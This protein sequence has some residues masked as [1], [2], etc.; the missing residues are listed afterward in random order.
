MACD[1][2]SRRASRT[3]GEAPRKIL[4]RIKTAAHPSGEQLTASRERARRM[5]L[6]G[7]VEFDSRSGAKPDHGA[8]RHHEMDF[9]AERGDNRPHGVEGPK[10]EGGGER[11]W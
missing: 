11:M 2:G 5:S 6:V 8:V 7:R 9:E 1:H 10:G 3:G 4:K